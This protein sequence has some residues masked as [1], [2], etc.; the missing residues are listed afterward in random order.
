VQRELLAA[1][2]ANFRHVLCSELALEVMP[3]LPVVWLIG[4]TSAYLLISLL[5]T[6]A[7][8]AHRHRFLGW[9]GGA[10]ALLAFSTASAALFTVSGTAVRPLA[11]ALALI[12]FVS[13]HLLLVE[14]IHWWARQMPMIRKDRLALVLVA[15]LAL[16][17]P[18][19]LAGSAGWVVALALCGGATLAAALVALASLTASTRGFGTPALAIPLVAALAVFGT[20]LAIGPFGAWLEIML[21]LYGVLGLGATAASM[22]Y[23]REAGQLAA[24][25][26]EHLAYYDPLTG[27]ANRALL[28]DRL[29]QAMRLADR[30][31]EPLAVLFFDVD[32]FK[33]IN[34]SLGHAVGDALLREL[35]SRVRAVIR[36]GDTFARYGGDEFALLLPR[37]GPDGAVFVA[38][39]L[40]AIIRKPH[41]ILQR[42][43]SITASVGI[44]IYPDDATGAEQL[45]G[46]ADKALY[47]C[48]ERGGDCFEIYSSPLG[49]RI[50]T[51][52]EIEALL[53]RAVEEQRIEAVYQPIIRLHDHSIAGV[54]TLLRLD[55]AGFEQL[56]PE[57]VSEVAEL[58]GLSLPIGRL[59]LE[60]ACRTAAELNA[61]GGPPLRVTVN[62]SSRQLR[63]KGLVAEVKEAL[64]SA[65]L[66]PHLLELEITEPAAL[67][68]ASR[69]SRA[70]E[71]LKEI[72]VTVAI[73]GYGTGVNSLTTLTSLPIDTLKIDKRF[74]QTLGEDKESVIARALIGMAHELGLR[75]VADGVESEEQLHFL[76]QEFCD[77]VQ[78]YHFSAP[79]DR[80]QLANF[81]AQHRRLIVASESWL[82]DSPAEGG[83]YPRALV[84]D[85]D[86]AIARLVSKLLERSGF[87]VDQAADGA[88]ALELID[89]ESYGIIFLDIM[90]PLVNGFEVIDQLRRERPEMLPSVVVMTA[91]A[92]KALERL[93]T[94]P[95]GRIVA[96]PFDIHHIVAAANECLRQKAS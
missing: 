27:L 92:P 67:A 47:R 73:D 18:L 55:E 12:F 77:L 40:L 48:K 46:A 28:F 63:S 16:A 21:V 51:R 35:A 43:I 25:Q 64:D 69:S 32:R 71:A 80:E 49:S 96:K 2:A 9:W 72:G 22:E 91:I 15:S 33:N 38:Q 81:V 86:P 23:E 34:D 90:M 50:R 61:D 85:D 8:F 17:I 79:L 59:L 93:A 78:G 19:A 52:L 95:I 1:C 4:A 88:A 62:I 76:Q 41:Q 66:D 56:T 6:T 82:I 11:G 57:V 58:S 10:F 68:D 53:R 74:V 89:R 30:D 3:Q 87:V 29:V 24:S 26:I 83:T 37:N 39:K 94:V 65:G 13:A 45:L 36:Q 31:S 14:G 7:A 44:S 60:Q 20:V 54:E 5:F 84:V 42:S 75:V 70:L